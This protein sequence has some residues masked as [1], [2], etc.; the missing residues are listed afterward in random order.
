[1]GHT[2]AV[3]RRTCP[4]SAPLISISGCRLHECT[5]RRTVWSH[6]PTQQPR[7][8]EVSEN[9][10]CLPIAL[11]GKPCGKKQAGP[12]VWQPRLY[13]RGCTGTTLFHVHHPPTSR[14]SIPG[15]R[16][17]QRLPRSAVLWEGAEKS[18]GILMFIL[19]LYLPTHHSSLPLCLGPSAS[20]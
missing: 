13:L 16:R 9:Q 18:T 3:P 10:V 4:F 8:G 19:S 5:P 14:Q 15:Q 11:E 20:I 17:L 7:I 2:T 6:L 1:M 12:H